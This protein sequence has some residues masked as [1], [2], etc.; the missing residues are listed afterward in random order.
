MNHIKPLAKQHLYVFENNILL[1]LGKEALWSELPQKPTY[2]LLTNN[3]KIH[4]E[5]WIEGYQLELIIADGSN[6][7]W[8]I[9]RWKKTCQ[10]KQIPFHAT[11]E[12][13][14]LKINL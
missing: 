5:R 12:Q 14:A 2:L 4:L 3:T 10:A 6:A 8:N 13:G 1:R 11:L 7:K 9:E